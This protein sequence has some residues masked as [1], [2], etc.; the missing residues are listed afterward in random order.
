MQDT[1]AD[2]AGHDGVFAVCDYYDLNEATTSIANS[3]IDG[4]S[5]STI[6]RSER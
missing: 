5:L 3:T 2:P 1:A 4:C 6:S